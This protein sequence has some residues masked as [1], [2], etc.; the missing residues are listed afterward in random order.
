MKVDSDAPLEMLAPLGCG[1]QT[2][3]GAVM[4]VLHPEPGST[5]AVFGVGGVGLAAI[6]AAALSGAANIVAVDVVA[7]RLE[8]ARDLGATHT[9]DAGSA[10]PVEALMELSSGLGVEYTIEATGSITVAEQA[11]QALAPLGTCALIG[12]PSFGSACPMDV[13]FMLNGGASSGSPRET[14]SPRYSSRRSSVCTNWASCHS[15]GSSG[16]TPSSS[17]NRR[18]ADAHSGVTIKP[19]LTFD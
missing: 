10:D 2:G 1:I 8:L 14:A 17:S 19:V 9:V 12:A 11:V 5:L 4:N 15:S 7:S 16:T 3:A 18:P 13:N 6:M